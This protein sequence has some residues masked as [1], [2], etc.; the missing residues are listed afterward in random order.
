MVVSEKEIE[1]EQK[2]LLR[3]APGFSA[4]VGEGGVALTKR[5]GPRIYS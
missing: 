5:P 4:L 3:G 2:S 1:E